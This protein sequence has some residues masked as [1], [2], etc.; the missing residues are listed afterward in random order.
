MDYLFFIGIA[1]VGSTLSA[2]FGLGSALLVIAF[3]S[4]VLPIQETIALATVMFTAGTLARTIAYRHDIDWRLAALM[5]VFSVPFAYIG[6]MALAVAPVEFLKISLGSIA[7]LYVALAFSGWKPRLTVGRGIIVLGAS[8]H[9]FMS[10]LLGT[11]NVIKAIIFDHMGLRKQAF[12]GLMAATSVAANFAKISRY[13]TDGLISER[14]ILPGIGL[15]LC[16]V[17]STAVGRR[18]LKRVPPDHFRNGVLL[19]L[20]AASIGLIVG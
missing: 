1:L 4:H 15:V 10:G 9:G 18:L 5:T 12:V 19:A 13:I 11:G 17:V 16:V 14:H 3:G 2:I 6:A 8:A 20:T 7:M